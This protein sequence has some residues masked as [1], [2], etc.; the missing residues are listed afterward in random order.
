ME[1]GN[2]MNIGSLNIE[3]VEVGSKTHIMGFG[4]NSE[5]VSEMKNN[6][7]IGF[8]DIDHVQASG[9]WNEQLSR[10]EF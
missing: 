1:T 6:F 4:K 2:N 3:K 10:I 8:H 7:V 9:I 5:S